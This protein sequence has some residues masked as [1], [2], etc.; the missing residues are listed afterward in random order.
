MKSLRLLSIIVMLAICFQCALAQ[1]TDNRKK[2][3]AERKEHVFDAAKMVDSLN[4]KLPNQG[5]GDVI[6]I[7]LVPSSEKV[8]AVG[9][10]INYSKSNGAG[11]DVMNFKGVTGVDSLPASSFDFSGSTLTIQI[12]KSS[13]HSRSA[14]H[15]SIPSDMSITL[16]IEGKLLSAGILTTGMIIKGGKIVEARNDID[17]KYAL[18]KALMTPPKNANVVEDD[19]AVLA[20]PDSRPYLPYQVSWKKLESL[21]IESPTSGYSVSTTT[22][23]P[24]C[25]FAVLQVVLSE[26]GQITEGNYITGDKELADAGVQVLRQYKFKPFV[27]DGHAVKARTLVALKVANGQLIFGAKNSKGQ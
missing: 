25:N 17:A 8:T 15:L 11:T 10:V 2:L 13:I 21:I 27:I 26:D 24:N 3:N 9:W 12:P 7:N 5:K 4:V 14:I 23:C 1:N 16:K 20:P 18:T 22:A 6:A 19:E